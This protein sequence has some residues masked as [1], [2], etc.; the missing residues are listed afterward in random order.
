[1]SSKMPAVPPGSRSPK[2]TGGDSAQAKG[3]QGPSGTQK[4]DPDRTGQSGN[5]KINTTHQGHQQ[6]R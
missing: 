2:G 6:D 4:G 5:T 3:A 1:M